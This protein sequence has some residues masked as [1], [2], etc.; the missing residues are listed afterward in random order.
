M[1]TIKSEV[2]SAAEEFDRRK[3]AGQQIA[4]IIS[5]TILPYSG[6]EGFYDMP[7][8]PG[9]PSIRRIEMP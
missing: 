9:I 7:K 8:P 1:E 2:I 4:N 5:R 3:K 6:T